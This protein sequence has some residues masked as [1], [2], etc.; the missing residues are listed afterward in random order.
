[1]VEGVR[2]FIKRISPFATIEFATLKKGKN[3]EEEGKEILK[4]L[5]PD[6]FCVALDENGEEMNSQGFAEFLG[7]R[8]DRGE[9]ICFVIGG[10]FGL[11]KDVKAAVKLALSF[12]KMTFTHQMIRLFLLE[13]I[14]R[15][16]CIINGKKY[17]C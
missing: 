5:S 3:V 1:M 13:Q 16:M 2:E 12:S 11:S 15:G 17:H 9:K 4:K 10:A 7:M 8:K 14:Y 6:Y